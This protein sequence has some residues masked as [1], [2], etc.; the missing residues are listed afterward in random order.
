[1]LPPERWAAVQQQVLAHAGDQVARRTH[2]DPAGPGRDHAARGLPVGGVRGRIGDEPGQRRPPVDLDPLGVHG[3]GD[4]PRPGADGAHRPSQEAHRSRLLAAAA[5]ERWTR[6]P[7][8]SSPA[9]CRERRWGSASVPTSP[10]TGPFQSG[11]SGPSGRLPPPTRRA[12]EVRSTPGPSSAL[13]SGLLPASRA[14]SAG[15]ETTTIRSVSGS[16]SRRLIASRVMRPPTSGERS[17]PPT[18]IAWEMP[19]PWWASR[20]QSCWT[21]VPDAPTIPTRPRGTAFQKP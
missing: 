11:G 2:G 12:T 18:P 13:T 10:T 1:A 15:L 19:A 5:L 4:R 3:L 7:A 9:R 16:S 17:R 14:A 6:A 8:A 20:Q 21:P